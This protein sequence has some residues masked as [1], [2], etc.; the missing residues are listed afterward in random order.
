MADI[1]PISDLNDRSEPLRVFVYGTLKPGGRYWRRFCRGRVKSCFPAW[2][3]GKLYELEAGYPALLERERGEE[4]NGEQAFGFVLTF[5]SGDA[6]AVLHE[7]DE[8]EGYAADFHDSPDNEYRRYETLVHPRDLGP[9][10]IG[11][12]SVRAYRMVDP[13]EASLLCWVYY[14]TEH[15][16]ELLGASPNEGSSWNHLA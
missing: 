7:L 9:T 4:S 3:S 6:E 12:P 2:V 8:L 15:T 16:V 10:E 14:A 11:F 13:P 5:A 1:P